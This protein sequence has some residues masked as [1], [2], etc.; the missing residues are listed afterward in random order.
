[1]KLQN[2]A[3]LAL[4]AVGAASLVQRER[5]HRQ[6]NE[7]AVMRNQLEWLRHLTTHPDFAQLWAPKDLTAEEYIKLL[8]VNQQ[9]C[10]LS[11]QHKLGLLRGRRLRFCADAVMK[12][13]YGRRYWERFGSFR[14]AEADGDRLATD[15]TDAMHD[16][17]TR[18]IKNSDAPKNPVLVDE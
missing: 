9:I 5:H 12:T 7:V 2:T 15:F 17:Y 3:A 13:E 4:V 11:L 10:A 6:K 18:A 14:E 8:H 16:A 1:M